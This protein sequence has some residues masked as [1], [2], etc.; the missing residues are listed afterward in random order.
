MVKT[1]K[2]YYQTLSRSLQARFLEIR[3][4]VQGYIKKIGYNPK[5]VIFCPISG[6]HG[7]NMLEKSEK[8]TWWASGYGDGKKEKVRPIKYK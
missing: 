4:E 6:W 3:K 1:S 8:M 7:D 2:W 5:E